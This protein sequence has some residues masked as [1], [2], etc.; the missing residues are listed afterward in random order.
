MSLSNDNYLGAEKTT[1]RHKTAM[2]KSNTQNPSLGTPWLMIM[3]M[4]IIRVLIIVR[5]LKA[6]HSLLHHAEVSQA[7]EPV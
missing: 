2:V 4:I 1:L 3:I 5:M 6:A 7:R